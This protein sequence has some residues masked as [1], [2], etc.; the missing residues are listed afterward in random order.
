M[1]LGLRLESLL[2]VVGRVIGEG[3]EFSQ[4]AIE[5]VDNATLELGAAVELL[6]ILLDSDSAMISEEELAGIVANP[7]ALQSPREDDD[8]SN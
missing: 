8:A 1:D 3:Q 6:Q 5:Q 2:F 4:R 7:E